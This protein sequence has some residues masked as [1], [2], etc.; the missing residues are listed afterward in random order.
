M[1]AIYRRE[2]DVVFVIDVYG[3]VDIDLEVNEDVKIDT[4]LSVWVG[5]ALN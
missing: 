5:T 3:I 2:G 1:L 4:G